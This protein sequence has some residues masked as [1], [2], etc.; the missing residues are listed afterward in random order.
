MRHHISKKYQLRQLLFR[1]Y[2]IMHYT[3]DES[4]DVMLMK[5]DIKELFLND[6]IDLSTFNEYMTILDDNI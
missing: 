2:Q 1:K 4:T 3:K 6:L 5:I